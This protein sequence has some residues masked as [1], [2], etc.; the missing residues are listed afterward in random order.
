MAKSVK[1]Y[2]EDCPKCLGAP[3]LNEYNG[4]YVISCSKCDHGCGTTRD[5]RAE[6]VAQWNRSALN[7]EC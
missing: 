7:S 4:K 3:K 2:L 5:S 6:I 1:I